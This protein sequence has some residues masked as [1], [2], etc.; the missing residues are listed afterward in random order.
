MSLLASVVVRY[1]CRVGRVCDECA[2]YFILHQD[3]EG[4]GKESG[5][6]REEVPH[7]RLLSEKFIRDI[8][9]RIEI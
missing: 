7:A 3:R 5:P 9:P 6:K 4:K 8:V 1:T 2:T